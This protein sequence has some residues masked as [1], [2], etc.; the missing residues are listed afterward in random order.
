MNS[1]ARA[2]VRVDPAGGG[3]DAP[4]Y[5][6]EH[7]GAVINFAVERYVYASAQKLPPGSGVIIYSADLRAGATAE[8]VSGLAGQKNLELLKAFVL[9]MVP[10]E[11]SLLL[12]TESD[13]PPDS[14][15]GGSAAVG[16]AVVAAIDGLYGGNR[17]PAEIA[18]LAND[19][20]RIDLGFPGGS[21]DSYGAALGDVNLIRYHHGGGVTPRRLQLSTQT[22]RTLEHHSLLIYTGGAHVSGAIHADIKRSYREND[23]K[24]FSALRALHLQAETMAAALEAGNLTGYANALNESCQQLYNLNASCDCPDH[25]RYFQALAELIAAGKTCGAGGGGFMLV[26]TQLGRRNDCARCAEEMG[27]LVWPITIDSSGVSRW[28][29]PPFDEAEVERIRHVAD[30]SKPG[31]SGSVA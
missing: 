26:L 17:S 19:V 29:E 8:R 5:C 22:R 3:T 20:E 31:T 18:A 27:A 25:R 4:P 23:G 9:R 6:V 16:V 7:G 2:P 12:L 10:D 13:V 21:Q 1:C 28:I 11:D 30:R 15:L 24:T 14:G